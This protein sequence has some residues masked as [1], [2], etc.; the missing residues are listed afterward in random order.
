MTC[1]SS[2]AERKLVQTYNQKPVLSQPQHK[3]YKGPNYFEIDL[4]LHFIRRKGLE[5]FRER[6]KHEVLD[7]GLTIEAQKADEL[8]EHVLCCMGLNKIDFA[9]QIPTP[10]TSA[11]E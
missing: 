10:I 4:D 7:L 6:L 5:T 8:P 1:S 3:F 2:T 11:D 9:G